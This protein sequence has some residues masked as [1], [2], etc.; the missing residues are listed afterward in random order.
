MSGPPPPFP[1]DEQLRLLYDL[2]G[3]GAW[4]W[5]VGSDRVYAHAGLAGLFGVTPEDAAGGPLAAYLRAIHPDDRA[6]V[7]AAISAAAAAADTYE[8]EYRVTG[9]DGVT[10]WMLARGRVERDAAGAAVRFP[11]VIQDVTARRQAEDARRASEAALRESEDRLAFTL[12]STGGGNWDLDLLTGRAVT[13]LRHDQCFG[14]TAPF[15]EWTYETFLAHVHPDDRAVEDRKFRAAVA[16]GRDWNVD[17]R[18]VWP[19]GSVHWIESSGRNYRYVDGRPTRMLGLVRDVT[20]RKRSELALRESEARYRTLFDGIDEGYC[21]CEMVTDAEGRPVDYRFLD[22]NPRFG[23]LTGIPAAAVGQTARALVPG[24]EDHWVE[25]YARAGLGGE[26]FRFEQGSEAMGRWFDVYVAPAGTPGDGRFALVFNDVTAERQAVLALRRSEERARLALDAAALGLWSWTPATDEGTQDARTREILGL[27]PDEA[28][29]MT[30]AFART[31][32]PDDGARVQAALDAALDPAGDG[33]LDLVHRMPEGSGRV[34]WVRSVARMEFEG[35]GAAR[36]PARM[37]GTLEDV[38]GRVEAETAR[39]E[40]E[41]RFRNMADHSPAMVWVTDPAGA[42]TYLN[43]RWYA[44]TGQTEAEGLGFGWLR[45]VHPDDAPRAERAFVEANAETAPFSLEYRLRRHDGA[46]RWAIDAASPRFG[47]D[48]AFLGYVGSVVDIT[49]QKA[50]EEALRRANA[51]LEA[52]V[53]ERTAALREANA[54]LV[55]RT[56]QLRLA[57][58][59]LRASNRELQD[60]AYVASHDLQEPLRKIQ[61]YAGLLQEEFG[62]ALP[63]EAA[64]YVGRMTWAAA[65]M[66]RLIADLLT[67]SRVASRGLAPAP[68]DVDAALDDV[69]ADLDVRLRE[70]GGRVER[71]GP[72]G[73]LAAD[74]VQLRQLLANLVGNGLKFHRPGVPPVVRVGVERGPEGA[75]L[76]V[77]DNGVGFEAKYAERIFGPFQRL[78]SRDVYEGTGV[79][80]AIVRKIAE[81]HGGTATA[82]ST[83]GEGSRFV[84]TL[85]SG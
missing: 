76:V 5:E 26:A 24:L 71:A 7:E 67:L 36:R 30:E 20:E 62:A 44:F 80:L 17:C 21:L 43:R 78:H 28:L 39:A 66:G 68:T 82:A 6:R 31:I 15:A 9:T 60:F 81:R 70:T 22:V 8:A 19:D 10:R 34:R 29:T 23:E 25:T 41:A 35:E 59:G 54:T 38:T 64:T 45:A 4:V 84:V 63:A 57:N 46:Y 16:S 69:L 42:C 74:P 47:E 56:D 27:G 73:P 37:V 72:L 50:A 85:P 61:T 33:R 79:G 1:A 2:D 11:G 12:E 13:S 55:E 32:H 18:V 52:R 3:I 48:G 75:A 65:R 53:A 77:E 49:D 51:A 14:A 40:S 58:D 83:P